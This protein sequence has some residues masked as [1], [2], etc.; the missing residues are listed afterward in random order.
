MVSL[1]AALP[2]AHSRLCGPGNATWPCYACCRCQV[3]EGGNVLEK[4]AV[5]VSVVAGVLT[6]E[7]A[8][9]MSS[10]GRQGVDPGG[11]QPYSAAALS[12]VFHSAHPLI[13]TLRADVRL[14]EV[15]GG[16]GLSGWLAGRLKVALL[17]GM[18]AAALLPTRE[19]MEAWRALAHHCEGRTQARHRN[20][21]SM[22]AGEPGHALR[23]QPGMRMQVAGQMWY[24][25]GCD[26]TPFYIIEEDVQEFHAFWKQLCDKYD[27]QVG[28]RA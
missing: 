25:G 11:G 23:V 2:K 28:R 12:L 7:R 14:F 16:D 4:G 3:L 27:L 13:P 17:E 22:T 5:N 21:P 10:R 24:G 15:R 19:G 26:L 1:G 6:P 9:A 18:L 8:K 20:C